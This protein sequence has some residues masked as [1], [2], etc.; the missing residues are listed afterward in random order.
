MNINEILLTV[1]DEIARDNGYILTEE[2]VIIGKNDW[3]WGNK[4]GFPNTQ[5][6]S[7]TYILP[8]WEE[9]QEGE[10]YFTRKIYLD[11]YWGKPRIHVKYPDG[12][13]CCLTYSNDGC[14]EAQA[15]SPIGLKKALW[16]QEKIDK[17]YN[18]EKYG[19]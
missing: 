8:A 17:L 10:D 12:A 9:E 7:R 5:V 3:F 16:I 2:R 19:R 11:M 18:R 14:I 1:A 15:F 4:V 13:F 6:K